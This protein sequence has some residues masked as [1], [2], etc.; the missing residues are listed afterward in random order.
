M[1]FHKL[2]LASL[3]VLAF[4]KYDGVTRALELDDVDIDEAIL[5]EPSIPV[6]YTPPEESETFEFQ[7]EVSRMLDIVVNSLYQNKDVFL[8][9]L[10]SNASDALDKIR[11]LSIENPDLLGDKEELEV[12]IE[13]DEDEGTLTITDSGIG[14]T[15]EDL[16]KNLGTVARS[17]TTKFLEAMQDGKTD[18]NMIGQFGVGFYS[19]FLVADRVRVSSK[20]A[21]DPVQHVWESTNGNSSFHIYADPRGNSLGR[22]TEITLFLKENARAYLSS[23]KLK[24]LSGHYSEFITHPIHVRTVDK[25]M[26]PVESEEDDDVGKDESDDSESDEFDGDDD[27]EEKEPEMEEVTTYEWVQVNTN[28]PLW[29][30]DKDVITVD[31]Y[32]EFF[33]ALDKGYSNATTWSH[34]EAEGNINFKS[35]LYLPSE[36]PD[37]L[38]YN[39]AVP[40]NPGL[41]LY[42][43]KVLISDTFELMPRYLSFI[44][45]VVDSNDLPL[46][47]N[48]E[49]LQESKIIKVIKKKL[50]RKAIEMIRKLALDDE[51]EDEAEDEKEVELDEMG[52]VVEGDD[53]EVEDE[54]P[55]KEKKFLTWYKK[56]SPSLKM[57]VI[58]DGAN[59]DKLLKLL[60]F[61]TSLYKDEDDFE[62]LE[63]YV[64]RMKD[65]QDEIY[66]FAGQDVK[67]LDNSQ[68]MDKFKSK[69]V[70]VLY[71]TDPIDEYM[72]Q[73]TPD[74][75]G[76]KFVAIN[77]E[78]VKF[79]DEDED[80]EKRKEKAYKKKYEPLINYLKKSYGS[81]VSKVVI[82]KRLERAPAMVSSSQYSHSA[83]MERILKAQ[84]FT[85]GSDN[86]YRSKAMK[87]FEINPRHP[88]VSA[89]LDLVPP[90]EDD[91]ENPFKVEE[92]TKDAIWLLH[93]VAML[94]SGFQITDTKSFSRR[95]TRVLKNQLSVES[96]LLEDE[97]D[98]PEE[99]DEPPELDDMGMPGGMNMED[100]DMSQF[101]P[102][103]IDDLD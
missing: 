10:I 37:Y 15:K 56:F 36:L 71:F 77:K 65:W 98:V 49:T 3:A 66:I 44:K 69:G 68:F 29:T 28:Q 60:R 17:G 57:G 52:N 26:V 21:D 70:E 53:L 30:R 50:V 88:F 80:F 47:V 95:M 8:R 34:F 32:Q 4:S 5:D 7:A 64:E 24:E 23:N 85:H 54:K 75:N 39:Q 22:G 19:S 67:D 43:R 20:N 82:S 72:I 31:E 55:P 91:E 46:N 18:L 81:N 87:V 12:R 45:G 73:N 13:Y 61:K 86:E 1:R 97:I 35:I 58:E 102:D 16:M 74:F 14:M 63:N 101:A 48:R 84:A 100:F 38:M 76:K 62:G 96:L 42:V 51:Q 93:D 59:K 90:V 94:N 25:K 40:E 79:K 11:F 92:T 99:D 41:N 9:E 33:K 6:D 78:N 27:E 89:L 2:A 83:N 103:D